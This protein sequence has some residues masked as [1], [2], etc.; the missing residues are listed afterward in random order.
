MAATGTFYGLAMQS[1]WNGEINYLTGSVKAMLVTRTYTP[2]QDT[3]RYKSSVTG[4][5]SGTGYT[6]RGQALTAKT[7]TYTAGANT[8][9][10]DCA[11]PTWPTATITARYL[12]VYVDTGNDATS[13]LIGYVDFGSDLTSAGGAFTYQVPA[14]GLI[15]STAT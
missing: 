12:V 10:L 4:E 9:A 11:D 8:L 7:V 5:I 6:A 2:N 15:T 13:P 3:H 14:A 1:L